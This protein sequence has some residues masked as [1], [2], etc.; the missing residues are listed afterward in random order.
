MPN[1]AQLCK[2]KLNTHILGHYFSSFVHQRDLSS[3][4]SVV[5]IDPNV[6]PL[7]CLFPWLRL[8]LGIPRG[9]R[10][11]NCHRH[12]VGCC[13]LETVS[14]TCDHSQA[15][16]NKEFETKDTES[17]LTFTNLTLSITLRC[18]CLIHLARSVCLFFQPRAYIVQFK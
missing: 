6:S 10:Q 17:T 11:R 12:L 8:I 1:C 14:I 7:I 4:W 9:T 5:T 3:G 18:D 16:L 15:F 13:S 2:H